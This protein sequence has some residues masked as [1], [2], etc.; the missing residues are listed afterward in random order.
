MQQLEPGETLVLLDGTYKQT[1]APMRAG[2]P[3]L[4]I[5]VRAKNPG[6]AIIDGEFSRL[7]IH[8][9]DYSFNGQACY[10]FEDLNCANG[11][12]RSVSIQSS[13]VTVK[14]CHIHTDYHFVSQ[15]EI[16]ALATPG[17]SY[18][19]HQLYIGERRV[20]DVLIEDCVLSG[21]SEKALKIFNSHNNIVRRCLV[22][23]LW[24]HGQFDHN[25]WPW[26]SGIDLYHASDNIVE[27]AVVFGTAYQGAIEH[28]GTESHPHQNTSENNEILGCIAAGA[29]MTPY[30][31]FYDFGLYRPLPNHM[32]SA[33][34]WRVN[35]MW[36]TWLGGVVIF[37]AASG[38]VLK[39]VV[40]I[41]NAGDGFNSTDVIYG[42]LRLENVTIID[43]DKAGYNKG[44]YNI[45]NGVAHTVVN[46]NIQ[47]TE[48]SGSGAD[49]TKRYTNGV[50][51]TGSLWPWPMEDRI[52]E[53][54]GYSVTNRIAAL[55]PGQVD[56]IADMD[57]PIIKTDTTWVNFE[58]AQTGQLSV[59]TISLTNQGTGTLSIDKSKLRVQNE[60]NHNAF[61]IINADALPTNIYP[62]DSIAVRIGF[63][64]ESEGMYAARLLIYPSNMG[65]LNFP[66]IVNLNGDGSNN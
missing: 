58:N 46:S 53:D 42:D 39:D 56:T 43:N 30:G 9:N 2:T 23:Q 11:F 7:C 37:G 24:A 34:D 15:A 22:D 33:I 60:A 65:R 8:I 51:T 5:T 10:I 64:P 12:D 40:S 55:L 36:D 4:P 54:L 50:K 16:D 31:E 20:H 19:T 25:V 32:G 13:H 17:T 1:L 48:Y 3:A 59:K 26:Y 66:H 14:R 27:N 29:G 61:T 38:V 41:G 63:Q 6:K 49:I 28:H 18:L 57:R 44:Q 45:N 62:G 21:M 52:R 47:G 35:V